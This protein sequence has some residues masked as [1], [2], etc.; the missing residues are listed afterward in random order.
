MLIGLLFTFLSI[1]QMNYVPDWSEEREAEHID[2]VSNQ[3]T[4]MR[5]AVDILSTLDQ[6][7]NK[8]TAPI[9]L[10]T[11]EIPLPFLR[12]DQS[13]GY[14]KI[15][16][17]VYNVKI[18][19]KNPTL[20]EFPLGTFEYSSVNSNYLN[21]EFI[22]EGGG[23]ITNQD[24]GNHMYIMPSYDVDYSTDVDISLD[25]IDFVET[26]GKTYT[27]GNGGIQIQL[28]YVQKNSN[29]INN[30]NTIAITTDYHS[31]WNNFF[32]DS[33]KNAGLNYGASDHYVIYEDEDDLVI[34]FDDTLSVDIILRTIEIDLQIGPGWSEI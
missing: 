17:D 4:Q 5:F 27:T 18:K 20:Y 13:F 3:F 9:T 16:S 32:N 8:I 7:G 14:I 29:T 6:S 28:E 2:N 23:V 12:S 10:G 11:Q 33:L 22:Y 34:D 15:I 31:S 26:S 21:V 24:N 1:V 30:V 25:V 19:D